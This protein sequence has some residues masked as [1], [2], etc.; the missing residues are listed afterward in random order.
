MNENET[1]SVCPSCGYPAHA[2]HSTNCQQTAKSGEEIKPGNA[3]NAEISRKIKT[4]NVDISRGFDNVDKIERFIAYLKNQ[5][6]K[7]EKYLYSGFPSALARKVRQTG[8]HSDTGLIFCAPYSELTSTSD[9]NQNPLLTF[10]GAEERGAIALYNQEFLQKD[11]QEGFY[12]YHLK[13]GSKPEQAIEAIIG[14]KV[15]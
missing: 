6:F 11:E 7:P 1:Q 14:V 12:A 3:S 10:A 2:G 13:E 8:T 4:G 15:N 9:S 5:G